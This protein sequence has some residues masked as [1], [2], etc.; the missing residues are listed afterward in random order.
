MPLLPLPEATIL[1]LIVT[2][3]VLILTLWY[4]ARI[5]A[6]RVPTRRPLRALDIMYAAL[7]RGAETGKAIHLSP[8]AGTIGDRVTTAETVVGLL[9]AQR[10]A[11]EAAFNGAPVLMSS[12]DA[13]AYL[14]LRGVMRQAYQAAGQSQEYRS[15]SVQL[16]AQQDQTAYATG[17]AAIYARQPFEASQLIGSFGQEYL[18]VGE[19]GTQRQVPQLVG[20]TSPV[21]L[22]LMLLTTSNTLIGEEVFAAEA[23]LA[24]TP[25]PQARLLT[26]DFLRTVV[27]ILIVGGLVYS[28]LQPSIGLP[29]LPGL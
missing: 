21:A 5:H 14:A 28:L 18:L 29:P 17:V 24:T 23:Y 6:G 13:V 1:V 10:V 11:N 3:V 2:L 19:E 25:T 27:I 20:S 8:G 22:P 4:H 9:A 16:L 15:A 12:G 26:Q 7:G